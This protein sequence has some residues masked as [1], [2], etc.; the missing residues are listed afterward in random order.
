MFSLPSIWNL[1]VSTIVFFIV[2]WLVRR[3]LD[4]QGFNNDK[5][6]DIVVFLFASL[7][8]WGAGEG[9]DWTQEKIEGKRQIVKN[10]SELPELQKVINQI[11]Q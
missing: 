10:S 9:A 5:K 8:S 1:V 4:K 6:R 2:A 11:P 7:V 3:L